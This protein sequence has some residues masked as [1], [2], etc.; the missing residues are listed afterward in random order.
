MPIDFS[1]RLPRDASA[2]SVARTTVRRRL[3]AQLDATRLGDLAVVV[4]ELVTNAVR[5][6]R[7]AITMRLQL[8]DGT[9]RGEVVDEGGGFEREIRRRGPA[10]VGGRGLAVVDG[11]TTRWG[12]HEGTTHVW[13]VLGG[14]T[15]DAEPAGPELGGGERPA[16]LDAPAGTA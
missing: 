15:S 3:G 16:D 10:E 8:D 14:D 4:S 13:F 7:G 9:V 6:G 2:P 1:V 11:L 5:H 12:V